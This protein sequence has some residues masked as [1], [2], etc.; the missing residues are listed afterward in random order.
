[1]RIFLD[2]CS[3]NRPWDDQ[4]QIRVHREAESVLFLVEEALDG[5]IEL[6]TSDYLVYEIMQIADQQRRERVMALLDAASFHV[7]ASDTLVRRAAEFALPSITGYDA[8][9]LATAEFANCLW[10]VTTDDKLLKRCKRASNIT[11]V[12]ALNPAEWPPPLTP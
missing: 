6:V 4:G 8:L 1:M 5:R 9:H 7:P 12:R 3:L 10:L 2:T 11:R